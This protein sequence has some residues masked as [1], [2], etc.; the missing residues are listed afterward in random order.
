[1]KKILAL[2]LTLMLV[3]A[4]MA[5]AESYNP[6]DHPVAICMTVVNHPVHRIVQLGFLQAAEKLGY[7]DAKVIGTES[8]DNAEML[9]AAEAF[10]PR[11]RRR[12]PAV[13]RRRFRL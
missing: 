5:L 11:R 10:A 7:T 8:G 9:A 13:G 2:V 3:L 6:A 4:P 1:M 12:P